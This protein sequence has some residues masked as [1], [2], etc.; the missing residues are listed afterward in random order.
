ML[1]SIRSGKLAEGTKLPSTRQ[2]S[3]DLGV[4][5]NTILAV[6]ERL[7]LDGFIESRDRSGFVVAA[8]SRKHAPITP[9]ISGPEVIRQSNNSTAHVETETIDTIL[10][11]IPPDWQRYPFPFIDGLFDQSLFPVAEWREASRRSLSVVD[12]EEWARDQGEADDPALIEQIQ[13]S[14]LILRGITAKADEI[15]ITT[16]AQQGLHLVIE[17]MVRSGMTVGLENPCN[18]ELRYLIQ[19]RGATCEF[20]DVDDEGIKI[21]PKRLKR[22]DVLFVSP[23]CQRPK[24]VTLST[25]RREKLIELSS[26]LSFKIIEDDYQWEIVRGETEPPA[27]RGSYGGENVIYAATLAQPIS[28]STRLGILVAPSPFIRAAR[29]F[30]RMTSRP[31]PL[32]TLRIL[33]YMISQGSYTSAMRR[34]EQAFI[35]RIAALHDALNHY[36]PT[37]VEVQPARLGAAAWIAGPPQLDSTQLAEEV[38]AK[39]VLIEPATPYFATRPENNV[40]RL[41]IT[42][43]TADNIRE[44]IAIIAEAIDRLTGTASISSSKIDPHY[45]NAS[46]IRAACEGSTLL[47]KTVYGEPCTIELKP[48]GQ[49]IGQAG[50]AN[51]DRDAGRWWIEDDHWCRQWDEWAYGEVAKFKVCLREGEIQWYLPGDRL[52][53]RAVLIKRDRNETMSAPASSGTID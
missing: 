29:S 39:G 18:P 36:L 43:I 33:H 41:G 27:L 20:F 11:G 17:L 2:L 24:G 16:G 30:R 8:Q 6:F 40:F 48:D 49:M 19:R 42:G 38:Q 35:S 7:M 14:I 22:C 10:P 37:R 13:R 23:V 46:D 53:D 12:I 9:L 25:A 21:D 31:P 26:T 47:C 1:D 45:L 51:E 5:R 32:S 28:A 52:I 3:K 15:I 44:G 50:Y 4:S 34:M